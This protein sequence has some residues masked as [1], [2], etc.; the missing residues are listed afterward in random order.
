MKKRVITDKLRIA[1]DLSARIRK[2]TYSG[3]V[4]IRFTEP[5]II[6][7]NYSLFNN[8]ILELKVIPGVI[9]A[10]EYLKRLEQE[11]IESWNITKFD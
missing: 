11:D 10:E 6:P 4:T 7:Q 2:I 3:L 5:L 8:E 9:D 1:P